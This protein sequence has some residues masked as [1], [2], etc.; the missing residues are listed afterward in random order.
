MDQ[1]KKGTCHPIAA[2]WQQA[3]PEGAAAFLLRKAEET[4]AALGKAERNGCFADDLVTFRN[5]ISVA[6]DN[7]SGQ[8]WRRF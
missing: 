2:R 7:F 8:H 1:Q 4:T 3:P 6:A 5:R